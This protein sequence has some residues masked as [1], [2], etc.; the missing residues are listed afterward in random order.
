MNIECIIEFIGFL[1]YGQS[2]FSFVTGSASNAEDALFELHCTLVFSKKERS[3]E[4]TH[5]RGFSFPDMFGITWVPPQTAGMG[6]GRGQPL[7]EL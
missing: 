3:D 1:N 2:F 6:R 5:L 7:G 4:L